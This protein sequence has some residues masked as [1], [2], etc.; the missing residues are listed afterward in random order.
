MDV[1][2]LIY[3]LVICV[4]VALLK[5]CNPAMA[6]GQPCGLLGVYNTYLDEPDEKLGVEH[7]YGLVFPW[8]LTNKQQS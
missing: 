7:E 8:C 4:I 3:K 1:V 5:E 6:I 2:I